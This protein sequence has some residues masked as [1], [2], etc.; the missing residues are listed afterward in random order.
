MLKTLKNKE[1]LSGDLQD[2][3]YDQMTQNTKDELLSDNIQIAGPKQSFE[4]YCC[5][6]HYGKKKTTENVHRARTRVTRPD[7]AENMN[8]V[9]EKY[10]KWKKAIG[11][12]K[13]INAY[14]FRDR[15]MISIL[16]DFMPN[17][18]RK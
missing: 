5:A 7:I 13:D 17:E 11:Y 8:Q 3:L 12:L 2:M 16:H 4:S 1:A 9:E 6:Y 18:I 14:D 10:K 15:S